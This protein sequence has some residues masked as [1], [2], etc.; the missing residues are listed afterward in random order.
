MRVREKESGREGGRE[1]KRERERGKNTA[2]SQLRFTVLIK[3]F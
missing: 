2:A 1:R 3:P